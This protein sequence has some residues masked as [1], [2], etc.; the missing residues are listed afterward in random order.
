MFLHFTADAA[1]DTD[2][3]RVMARKGFASE[4]DYRREYELD[5]TSLAGAAVFNGYVMQQTTTLELLEHSPFFCGWDWGF[6]HPSLV[7]TQFNEK[8]QWLWQRCFVG[9]EMLVNTFL[10]VGCWL[11][12]QFNDTMLTAES[13]K[14]IAA[15]K[16]TQWIPFPSKYSYADFCDIAGTYRSDRVAQSNIDIARQPPFNLNMRFS[17]TDPEMGI[18]LM[19]LRMRK[20]N[21]GLYGIMVDGNHCEILVHGCTGGFVRDSKGKIDDN[22]YTNPFDALRYIIVNMSNERKEQNLYRGKI[23]SLKGIIRSVPKPLTRELIERL[24]SEDE[25]SRQFSKVIRIT[26]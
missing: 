24:V 22:F 6:V 16:L 4:R 23:E 2:E 15:K 5:F 12:G 20:R 13:R 21:D 25:K 11:R 19:A 14:Y 7:L 17:K 10:E 18:N 3:F 8:D 1:K 9:D 26:A